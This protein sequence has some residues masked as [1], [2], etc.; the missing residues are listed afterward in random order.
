MQEERP[1]VTVN[2]TLWRPMASHL[3]VLGFDGP[4]HHSVF[5]P[6]HHLVHGLRL[7][8]LTAR[9]SYI[10]RHITL[11]N[12]LHYKWRLH[13]NHVPHPPQLHRLGR[14]IRNYI[15][16]SITSH[17]VFALS[18]FYFFNMHT[19]TIFHIVCVDS[20]AWKRLFTLAFS[21]Y[22]KYRYARSN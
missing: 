13:Q 11:H 4:Q 20:M 17:C 3:A 6:L 21:F 9:N 16:H 2:G 14:N 19:Q 1:A 15:S 8:V 7:H 18:L 12:S 10:H 22:W 5:D